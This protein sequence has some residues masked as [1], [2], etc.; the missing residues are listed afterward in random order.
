MT[1]TATPET[2]PV[3]APASD[4]GSMADRMAAQLVS[5]IEGGG[6]E[7]D[8][9]AADAAVAEMVNDVEGQPGDSEQEPGTEDD[10]TEPANDAHET[11]ADATQQEHTV[12]VKVN[13]EEREVPLSEAIAGY[14]RT[15]D[16]KQKTAALA[17]DRRTFEAQRANIDADL[18]AEYANQLEQATKTFAEFDPVLQEARKI[19]WDRL[20]AT[21]PAA[22]VQASDAVNQRLGLIDQMQAQVA[23]ARQEAQ[24]HSERQEQQ[25]RAQR[26]DTAAEKIVEAM[27][28]LADEAKFQAFAS[29]AIGHLK[30]EGFSPEEIAGVLDHRVLTLADK[31]RRWDAYQAAQKS[32]PQKKIVPRSTIK[33]MTT[34]GAS[35]RATSPR[36]PSG[37][38]QERKIEW[39]V[40]RMLEQE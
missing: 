8:A 16:Y 34:D 35:S 30:G 24:Q 36:L 5:E 10:A 38:S 19:D 7:D 37:A 14:S 25:D 15:E 23:T 33:P 26:F 20:K 27:P 31:A 39:A 28:E 1:D 12:T 2:G 32:L 29:D 17:Q 9:S 22:Y 6:G 13:G 21:D 3:D 11:E 4:E 18:K 40:Q